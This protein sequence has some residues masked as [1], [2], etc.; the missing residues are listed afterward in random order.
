MNRWTNTETEYLER[1]YGNVST[2]IIALHLER[3]E[4]AVK[5]KANSLG[6][7]YWKTVDES[8]LDCLCEK[9]AW[10][11]GVFA[12]DGNATIKGRS[13]PRI[14][15]TMNDKDC[16]EKLSSICSCKN[17]IIE[18][19]GTFYFS[20]TSDAIYQ[21]LCFLFGCTVVRKSNTLLFP[22]LPPELLCHFT[23]GIVDG[24]GCISFSRNVPCVSVVC[25]S[26]PFLSGL[27][28][29]IENQTGIGLNIRSNHHIQQVDCSGIKAKCLV[30]WL[31]DGCSVYM[32]RKRQRAN[33]VLE[34][35]PKF[36]R[37]TSLTPKMC[38]VFGLERKK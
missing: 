25:G 21:K 5:R 4:S 29:A 18:R 24:D 16:I 3:Q 26:E 13:N 34:W 31:Y 11:L 7:K 33:R 15:F 37:N 2:C 28:T 30:G 17:R 1:H 14:Q 10:W 22:S 38:D 9:T 36:I 32:D 6:L 12:A 20:F 23:R 35:N 27:K 8:F 19:D